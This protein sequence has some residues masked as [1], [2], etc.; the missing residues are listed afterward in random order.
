[1]NL[2][3]AIGSNSTGF[4]GDNGSV[5]TDRFNLGLDYGNVSTTRRHRWLTTFTYQLPGEHWKPA[6]MAG[7][8][9]KLAAGGWQLSGIL[10]FQTGQY[11]TPITGGVTD[12]SGTNV[13]SRANDRP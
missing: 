8:A 6:S 5:P 9:A 11:L 12:P 10:L 3:N 2:S 13:D 1:K 7:Q 4:A